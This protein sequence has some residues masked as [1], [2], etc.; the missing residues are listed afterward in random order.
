LILFQGLNNAQIFK[1]IIG[2]LPTESL[3]S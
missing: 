2:D 1:R 3:L